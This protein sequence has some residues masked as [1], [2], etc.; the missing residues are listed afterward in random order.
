VI[1]R[2]WSRLPAQQRW[3]FALA[4]VVYLLTSGGHTYSPDEEERY[5]VAR[6]LVEQR[7][8]AVA[9]PTTDVA[10]VAG[11]RL[12]DGRN[13]SKYGLGGS[14]VGLPFYLVGAAAARLLAAD[15]FELLTRAALSLVNPLATAAT[16]VLLAG[17]ARRLGAGAR[18]AV[19]LAL[20]YGFTSFAWVYARTTFVE[21]LVA[22]ALTAAFAAAFTARQGVRIPAATR[23][24]LG[25]VLGCGLALGAAL[26]LRLDTAIVGPLFLAYLLWPSDADGGW[27]TTS[28]LRRATRSVAALAVGPVLALAVA[29]LYNW[30]RFGSALETGYGAEAGRFT[31]PALLGFYGLLLSPGRGLLL[32][33][34]PILL[35]LVGA[36]RFARRWPLEAGLISGLAV[37]TVGFFARWSAWDGGGGWGPR[38]LLPILPLAL[39]PALAV[40]DG[41]HQP[42]TSLATG[43]A[44]WAARR[45][46]VGIAAVV[47]AGLW[48]QLA[49][50]LV[51]FAVVHNS[52]WVPGPQ[53]L[54][55][56]RRYCP[57]L[58]HWQF[59]A[60]NAAYWWRYARG[61]GV[62]AVVR[63]GLEIVPTARQ[64]NYLP[65]WTA[66][67]LRLWLPHPGAGRHELAL[68]YD[69]FRPAEIASAS[70]RAFVEADVGSARQTLSTRQGHRLL[71]LAF[72]APAAGGRGVVVE[73]IPWS[74]V[75]PPSPGRGIHLVGIELDGRPLT[76]LAARTPPPPASPRLLFDWFYHPA[77]HHFDLWWWYALVAGFPRAAILGIVMAGLLAALVAARGLWRA[78]ASG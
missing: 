63:E 46:M 18:A 8:L 35:A 26:L 56:D 49:G 22:L 51:N 72:D 15:R 23:S 28:W 33:A 71:S 13:Y 9:I 40:L 61:S 59:A 12:V 42:A 6:G 65:S 53:Q 43:A 16:L 3:L 32:Y 19:G 36:R 74:T 10:V 62:D 30:A 78:L 21:P 7:T 5:Y 39:L 70:P 45:R 1:G 41:W 34:P 73:S 60:D 58:G 25:G 64:G 20:L 52:D 4:L 24:E 27:W 44:R 69:E 2:W 31:T 54:L 48:V 37:L 57:V 77:L 11:E 66:P 14:L 50:V 38:L 47:A 68:V 55:F 76:R 75:G 17:L 29:G 67:R